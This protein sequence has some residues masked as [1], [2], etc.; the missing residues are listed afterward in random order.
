[1]ADSEKVFKIIIVAPTCFYYQT[2]LFRQLA[3]HPRFDLLVLFCSDEALFARDAAAMYNTKADW[4]DEDELLEGYNHKFI[5][6][7]SLRPSYLKSYFGL[8]NLGIWS[9][10]KKVGPDVV[11]IMSWMNPTWWATVFSCVARRIPFLFM[12]DANAQLEPLRSKWKIRAKR[13]VLGNFLFRLA[14]GFLYGGTANQQ[15]YQY[16]GVPEDKLIPFAYSWGYESYLEISEN[17]KS[18]RP[19]LMEEMGIPENSFVILFVGRLSNGKGLSN[20]MEAFDHAQIPNKA[21]LLVGDGELKGELEEYVAENNLDS[22]Y[23][24]GFQQRDNI[25]KFYAIS[26]VLVL[27][28]HRETWGI[29]VSEAMCFRLPLIVSDQVGAG[30]DMVE[31][32]R[33]G[34]V[35]PAAD[36]KALTHCLET[37]AV[38]PEEERSTMGLRSRQIISEWTNRNLLQSLADYLDG[39]YSTPEGS[40]N[41]E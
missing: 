23:F 10:I 13:L 3:E 39:L 12:T 35:I 34:Y 28:S 32:G 15:L 9:E 29:V 1:M 6:N 38:L 20:L 14:S 30:P 22:V 31:E 2:S 26:D 21:L 27:P 17:L 11:V 8:I 33:N 40:Q 25:P 37:L 18:Q 41:P 24:A 16:Y 36:S 5:R 4:G 19:H 7:Y